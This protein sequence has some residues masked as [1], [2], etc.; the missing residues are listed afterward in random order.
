MAALLRRTH[1]DRCDKQSRTADLCAKGVRLHR[2]P[3]QYVTCKDDNGIRRRTKTLQAKARYRGQRKDNRMIAA[4]SSRN[5]FDYARVD[6]RHHI[7]A[8]H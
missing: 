2:T 7:L 4:I 8:R 1:H 6:E 5:G 3:V